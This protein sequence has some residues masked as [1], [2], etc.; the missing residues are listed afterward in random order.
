MIEDNTPDSKKDSPGAKVIPL[1]PNQRTGIHHHQ[2]A[3]LQA[4]EQKL[5]VL[6]E[7]I[8]SMKIPG[9]KLVPVANSL[10]TELIRESDIISCKA[11]RSYTE[12]SLVNGTTLMDSKGLYHYQNTL[13][14]HL[15]FR[16]NRS[17]IVNLKMVRTILGR[18]R[19]LITTHG[20]RVPISESLIPILKDR[21]LNLM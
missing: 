3:S 10:G 17:W 19:E 16:T 1:F 21:L 18:E 5:D 9:N 8:V 14:D 7:K 13:P 11:N 6:I 20:S 15:F 2:A 12:L 4:I